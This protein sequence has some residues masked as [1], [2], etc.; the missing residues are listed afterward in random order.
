M[1]QPEHLKKGDTVTIIS[2]ARKITL[3]ELA[4]AISLFESW[5]LNVVLGQN[6]LGSFNQFSGTNKERLSDLQHAINDPSIKAVFFARGGY[7]TGRL[8]DELDLAPLVN[9]A[10]WLVGYSDLTALHLHV[11]TSLGL[12]SIHGTMPINIVKRVKPGDDLS[13]ESL[14]KMLFGVNQE[15]VLNEHPLNVS[16]DCSGTLV[17]GNLS[18]I[19]SMLGSKSMPAQ[20]DGILFLEDLDE[21]LYHIDRMMLNLHRNGCLSKLKGVLIGGLSDMNDNEIP[22]GKSAEEIVFEWLEPLGIPLYFGLQFGHVSPN[23]ALPHGKKVTIIN[24]KLLL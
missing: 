9:Q 13:V 23:L 1:I 20:L 4:P 2:T 19:Y 11:F 22:F 15:Y 6:L 10:K 18:I 7:G 12:A 14:R 5:G 24:N 16:G 17:G 21:Y 3:N 8:L